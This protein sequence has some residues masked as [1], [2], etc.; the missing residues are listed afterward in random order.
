MAIKGSF[1][2]LFSCSLYKIK[3]KLLIDRQQVSII[4]LVV[5]CNGWLY[6]VMGVC[7]T[8]ITNKCQ[9]W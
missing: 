1:V 7:D 8:G 9:M 6:H 2:G 5:E 4:Q 3:K